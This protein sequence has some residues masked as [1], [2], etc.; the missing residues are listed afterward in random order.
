MQPIMGTRAGI[1]WG[2][3]M[4]KLVSLLAVAA[5]GAG[6]AATAQAHDVVGVGIGV[7]IAPAY[8]VYAAPPVYYAPPPVY[9]APP[10]VYYGYGYWP[11]YY[12]GYY[13]GYYGGPWGW[14]HHYRHWR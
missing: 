4:K 8:P 3:Q 10:P 13:R 14:H 6:F 5:L 11:G 12:P 7:P 2:H 1:T 9:Y